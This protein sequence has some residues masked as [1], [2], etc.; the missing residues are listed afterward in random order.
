MSDFD[1]YVNY[2]SL[3][4]C[5]WGNDWEVSWFGSRTIENCS[6]LKLVKTVL[7]WNYVTDSLEVMVW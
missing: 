2:L 3:F 1:D 6:H 7:M 4:V 5:E